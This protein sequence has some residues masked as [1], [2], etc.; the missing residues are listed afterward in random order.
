MTV[1]RRRSKRRSTSCWRVENRISTWTRRTFSR[2][3]FLPEQREDLLNFLQIV[4][5]GLHDQETT[6]TAEVRNSVRI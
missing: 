6:T 2:R 3:R 4:V 5:R 1:V